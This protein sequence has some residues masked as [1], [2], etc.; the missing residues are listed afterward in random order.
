MLFVAS[1][2]WAEAYSAGGETAASALGGTDKFDPCTS[3]IVLRYHC[4]IVAPK[5]APIEAL[6]KTGIQSD[7]RGVV[8]C[9]AARSI[10]SQLTTTIPIS[11]INAASP[12]L[13]THFSHFGS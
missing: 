10:W 2:A 9:N 1:Y 6:N 3:L 12:A 7:G 4:G 13:S 8:A 11:A 5:R